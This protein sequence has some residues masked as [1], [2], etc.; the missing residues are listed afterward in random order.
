MW[1]SS[2]SPGCMRALPASQSC[3]VR[4]V[5]EI[6]AA[7]ADWESPADSRACRISGGVGLFTPSGRLYG[8]VNGDRQIAVDGQKSGPIFLDNSAGF[9][10]GHLGEDQVVFDEVINFSLG[11]N[12]ANCGHDFLRL[13]GLRRATH[14]LNY[15]RNPCNGKS[16]L[17]KFTEAL[18]PPHNVELTGD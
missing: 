5:E 16:F 1:N 18:T 14:E 4:S 8:R 6:S 10:I 12:L 13:F 15:T 17:Q 7:A 9:F 11:G 2:H 3:Q